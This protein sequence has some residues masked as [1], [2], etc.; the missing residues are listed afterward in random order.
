MHWTMGGIT[1]RRAQI[2][3]CRRLG[4]TGLGTAIDVT[5]VGAEVEL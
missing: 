4:M 3:R 1:A 2:H 5:Q